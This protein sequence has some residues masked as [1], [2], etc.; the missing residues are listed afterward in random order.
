MRVEEILAAKIVE[1][2]TKVNGH[3]PDPVLPVPVVDWAAAFDRP[4]V[5]AVVDGFL[6]PGRWTALVAP[7]KHGKSTLALHI[8]HRLARGHEPFGPAR[9]PAIPVLYLDGEMGELDVVERLTSLELTP[10]QLGGLH[11]SDRFPKGDTVQGGAAIVSTAIALAVGVVV[12]D[13]LNAFV[14]GA[15]KD[16]TP[17]RNLFDNTIAPLKRAGIA[18]LSDDNTGKDTTLSARGSSVKLDK[19]DAIIELKRTDGGLTLKTTHQRSADYIKHL[20]LAMDGLDGERP[21]DYRRTTSAWPAGTHDAVKLLEEFGVDFD[22]GRGRAREI[23]RANN[24]GV[25]NEVLSAALKLRR[26][27]VTQSQMFNHFTQENCPG[28]RSSQLAGDS[29]RGQVDENDF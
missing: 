10:T 26:Q 19:A 5:D 18:V 1:Q 9:H 8:A 29:S 3:G 6:F 14:T 4:V 17:W 21:I 28:D 15:E 13:G 16:D 20:D 11:Y 22:A 12:L 24:A 25:R 2:A 27:T 7:A 23:L